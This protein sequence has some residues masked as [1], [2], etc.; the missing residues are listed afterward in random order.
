MLTPLCWDWNDS[1]YTFIPSHFKNDKFSISLNSQ[2]KVFE[3]GF[4]CVALAALELTEI[5]LQLPP[6]Y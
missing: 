1:Y 3:I 2:M 5:C 4:L 6:K